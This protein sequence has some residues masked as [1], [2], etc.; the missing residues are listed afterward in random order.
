[1]RGRAIWLTAHNGAAATSDA[2]QFDAEDSP[3]RP[4]SHTMEWRNAADVAG[5]SQIIGLRQF[6]CDF[7]CEQPHG[8]FPRLWVVDEIVAID[9]QCAEWATQFLKPL[10]ELL[11]HRVG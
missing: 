9:Q 8:F 10:F 7:L 5:P 1:M 3:A 11:F 6:W 2:H 4:L